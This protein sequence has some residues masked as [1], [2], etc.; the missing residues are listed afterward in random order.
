MYVNAGTRIVV[1][2]VLAV[3]VCTVGYKLRVSLWAS[4]QVGGGAR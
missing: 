1:T 2:A 4:G 3:V